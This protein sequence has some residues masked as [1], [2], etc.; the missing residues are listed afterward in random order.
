VGGEAWLIPKG[1]DGGKFKYEVRF[2][3]SIARPLE[4]ST[5]AA[6]KFAGESAERR[7]D[8]LALNTP[9]KTGADDVTDAVNTFL[10]KWSHGL[11]CIADDADVI[12]A[13]LASSINTFLVT[14]TK[15]GYEA[16][17][18][19]LR[20]QYED[21]HPVTTWLEGYGIEGKEVRFERRTDTPGQPGSGEE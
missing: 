12:V 11:G 10:D 13:A 19:R 21:D 2:L 20:Q 18:V 9:D 6:R 4:E 5:A 7:M 16:R 3:Q 15:V 17:Q 8:V 14:D 1:A